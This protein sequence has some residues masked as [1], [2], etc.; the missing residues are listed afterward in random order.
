MYNVS[1]GT[2]EKQLCQLTNIDNL[3]VY[4]TSISV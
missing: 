3:F 2:Y 4:Y 1:I